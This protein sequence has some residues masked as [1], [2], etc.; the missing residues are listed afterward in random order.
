MEAEVRTDVTMDRWTALSQFHRAQ[1]A[2]HGEV[3]PARQ[4]AEQRDGD[5]GCESSH[6]RDAR[7]ARL[8]MDVA[9]EHGHTTS[10]A[11]LRP[12]SGR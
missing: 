1:H 4:T 2:P 8:W 9:D 12:Q 7:R 10:A 6:A 5:K 11:E 3:Q